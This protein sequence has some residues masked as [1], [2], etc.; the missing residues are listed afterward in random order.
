MVTIKEALN[1]AIDLLKQQPQTNKNIEIIKILERQT[2][3]ESFR[4]WSKEEIFKTIDEWIEKHKRKPTTT[5][6]Q[7]IGMPKPITIKTHFGM[8]ATSFLKTYYNN[9]SLPQKPKTNIYGFKT[10]EDWINCFVT[11]FKKHH[12]VARTYNMLRD[13]GTPAWET[14][15]RHCGSIQWR[16]LMK[17]ANVEYENKHKNLDKP[18][19]IRNIESPY[20]K[21]LEELYQR[22]IESRE[23][24]IKTVQASMKR[25][26]NLRIIVHKDENNKTTSVE[27][28]YVK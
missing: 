9:D 27:K 8:K 21:H 19:Y 26:A 17:L 11:Q 10:Q 24:L 4:H 18:V 6:L 28:L 20:L 16:E 15:S 23:E 2:H 25:E 13:K 12:P 7:E 5:S 14:I 22:N 1:V 3:K